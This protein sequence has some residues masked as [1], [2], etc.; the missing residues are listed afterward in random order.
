M[1]LHLFFLISAFA[2]SMWAADDRPNIVFLLTDDQTSYS[3]GCY[4]N[5]DVQ[6]PNIDRL[7]DQGMKFNNHYDTTA[8]CMA[9]RANVVTGRYEYRNG[10]NFSHGHLV[11]D[12]WETSYPVLLRNAGYRTAIAGKIGFEVTDTPEGKGYLPEDDFDEWGAGPGQTFYETKKNKSMAKYADE[13]PHSTLSYGAFGRDFIASSAKS[14]QPFCL[15]ISFKAAHRPTTPD[16][17]FDDVYKGKTFKKPANYGREHGEHFSKQSRQ[18]RQYVRFHEWGYSDRYDEVM[19]IYHQQV[20]GVDVAVG[21]IMEALE[22]HGVA[23]NT[24]VVFTSDNG[25]F[26]GSHGYGSKVLPYEES[27]LVP[28]I[29]YDP[30]HRN[31]GKQLECDALTGN[32]DFA[33]TFLEL[34]G[35]EIPEEMDGKSLVKLYDKPNSAIHESLPLINVWGPS[36]VHSLSIVTKDEKFIYWPH[37]AEGFVATEELYITSKDPLELENQVANPEYASTLRRMQKLYDDQVKHWKAESVDFHDYKQF[38]DIFD[39]SIE[40]KDKQKL[41][42][43]FN[44]TK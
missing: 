5:P 44:E 17:K 30:R 20:Y 33:P 21:M 9:S 27:A 29:M 19:A 42:G 16:P 24:I 23:D 37:A 35:L 38:G 18:G 11:R 26:C 3:L 43:S 12:I 25:F 39:R 7:A 36:E 8:I 1:K 6:T 2:A 13:Y 40:W 32:V 34:A 28:L 10:C 15:S 41:V 22:K 4:G 31:S 14:G